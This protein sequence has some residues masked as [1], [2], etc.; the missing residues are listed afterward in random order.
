MASDVQ[1]LQT[2]AKLYYEEE[3][4]QSEIGK[5][6][7]ISRPKVSRRLSE[8]KERGI[9]KIFIEEDTD[10]IKDL[11]RRIYSSFPVKSVHIA[12]VPE[13]DSSMAVHFTARLG[14][15]IFPSYLKSGDR[16]G[17]NWGWTLYELSKAFPRMNIKD[18][19][20]VQLSGAVDNA[21]SRSYATEIIKNLSGKINSEHTYFLPCP[22]LVDS[23]IIAD[24]MKSD[25]KIR[26]LFENISKCNKIFINITTPD[27]KS[28]IYEAGYINDQDLK[29]LKQKNAV[30]IICSRFYNENGEIC[31]KELDNRTI[32]IPLEDI[33][34]AECVFACIS[35]ASKYQALYAALKAGWI[36]V[37]VLD[38]ILAEK[39]VSLL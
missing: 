4:T 25:E 29:R 23:S 20:L 16:I 9:V 36:D 14:A 3:K 8:A 32:G 11:E 10:E 39:L 33:R 7:G 38:S 30:G 12:S 19:S 1:E 2:I 34:N 24:A 27:E 17:V 37:L 35:G 28:C 5:M 13:N 22:A 26:M 31:D 18:C 6:L 21:N 15:E